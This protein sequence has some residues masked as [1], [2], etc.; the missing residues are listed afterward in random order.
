[1]QFY[2]T[3][4]IQACAFFVACIFFLLVLASPFWAWIDADRRGKTGCLWALLVL[5]TW[6]LGLIAYLILRDKEVRL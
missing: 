2:E 5:F 3:N 1:M 6:P 4:I